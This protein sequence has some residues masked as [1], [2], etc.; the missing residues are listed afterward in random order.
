[1]CHNFH[2]GLSN[3]S[4][5]TALCCD[6]EDKCL[7]NGEKVSH[8][9]RHI[10]RFVSL[11]CIP[12]NCCSLSRRTTLKK[13]T[14]AAG[15]ERNICAWTADD[16]D[17]V[18]RKGA[19][20][21]LLHHFVIRNN[22]GLPDVPTL[23]MPWRDSVRPGTHTGDL[24]SA[25]PPIHHACSSLCMLPGPVHGLVT[26]RSLLGLIPGIRGARRHK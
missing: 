6:C 26:A 18:L 24:T 22:H 17:E 25:T 20:L 21:C 7:K 1:M 4:I 19:S 16:D 2:L 14:A 9:T 3:D 23:N 8:F 10:S 12:Q 15:L 13:R 5:N 11:V